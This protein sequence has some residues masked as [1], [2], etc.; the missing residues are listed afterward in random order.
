MPSWSR[1]FSTAPHSIRGPAGS[2]PSGSGG[3]VTVLH[4]RVERDRGGARCPLRVDYQTKQRKFL[5]ALVDLA[6]SDGLE[7]GAS[8]LPTVP[9]TLG[10]CDFAD[11]RSAEELVRRLNVPPGTVVPVTFIVRRDTP[12]PEQIAKRFDYVIA[13]HVI[14]HVPNM[15]GYLR[16]VATLGLIDIQDSQAG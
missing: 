16:E 12:L 13:C 10:R 9:A 6:S 8:D 14:E 1:G 2:A 15:I 4:S 7:I 3:A 5:G 11:F